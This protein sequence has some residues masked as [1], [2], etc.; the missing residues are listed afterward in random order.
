M[1]K[2]FYRKLAVNNIKRN[3]TKFIPYF[4]AA[5]IMISVYFMTLLIIFTP[6]LASVPE[7]ASLKQMFGI[8]FVVLNVFIAIFMLYINSFLIKQRKKELG[9]YG[10][11]GLEKRHIGYV[12]LWENLF[13]NGSAVL[14][15]IITGCVFGWLI[16]MLLLKSINVSENS[17]F[18]IPMEAFVITSVFFFVLFFV[19]SILN[20][21]QIRLANPIDLLK[22]DH[23]GEKKTHFLI[24]ITIFG[25][26]M[27]GYAY[28][29]SCTVVSPLAA[30]NRFL[31][32][33]ILVIIA[34]YMLFTT[35]SIAFL[36]LLKKNKKY[37]YKSE[38]FISIA[39]M[40]HRMKQNA[41]GLATICILSTM[42]LVTV[43]TCFALYIGQEDILKAMYKDDIVLEFFEETTAKEQ[44]Q[45][46]EAIHRTIKEHEVELVSD[47]S[48]YSREGYLTYEQG[49]LKSPDRDYDIF[50][51]DAPKEIA[52]SIITLEDFNRIS[53]KQQNLQENE[54][55][56]LYGEIDYSEQETI[57]FGDATNEKTYHIASHMEDTIF[58]TGKNRKAKDEIYVVV[59]DMTELQQL[60]DKMNPISWKMV[61]NLDSS[62]EPGLDFSNSLKSEAKVFDHF[63]RIDSIFEN[64]AMCYSLYG[65][66]LFMG[67]FFTILFLCATVLIIYFKQISEGYEDKDRFEM[68]QKVGMDDKEV[69]RTINKQILLVFFLPLL[70]ALLHLSMAS[71]MIIKL[72]QV[73]HLY[74]VRLTVLCMLS[75]CAV[76]TIVYVIVYRLTA[77]TYCKIVKW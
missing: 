2:E 11:L 48:Y 7:S 20:I 14:L 58:T 43:S 51:N 40:F 5:T 76:F 13:I 63:M 55:L 56:L 15:G 65:G 36:T 37:Y 52:V 50:D 32:A 61:I 17:Y 10:I 44:D 45:I 3:R 34:S 18:A 74:N 16:F 31:M 9:L 4:I 21:I 54:I 72:L 71:N 12:M 68:L 38:N 67:A 47:Y 77:K 64:R 70:G 1:G 60:T 42:V 75:S 26:L 69:K 46:S 8:G 30:L 23:A 41:S 66:L 29:I 49:Q 33:V 25:L 22:S 73:F 53:G 39:G 19:I 62:Q 57:T 28:Y 59:K 35:G 24:P 6:G 27:L